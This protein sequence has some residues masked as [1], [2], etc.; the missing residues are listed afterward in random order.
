MVRSALR[1]LSPLSG[2]GQTSSKG[3]WVV[4]VHLRAVLLRNVKTIVRKRRRKCQL[5][6]WTCRWPPG[7][8]VKAAAAVAAALC[9]SGR[10]GG[11]RSATLDGA[12]GRPGT[13]RLGGRPHCRHAI[14]GLLQRCPETGREKFAEAEICDGLEVQP[15][16][17]GRRPV[18]AAASDAANAAEGE[19]GTGLR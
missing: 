4:M 15:C 10:G 18:A 5:R 6:T 14:D 2:C 19:R 8:A 16:A 7:L 13:L 1:S 17:S 3:F 12:G 9:P 11:G